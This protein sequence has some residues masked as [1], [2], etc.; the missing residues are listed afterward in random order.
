MS[1][2]TVDALTACIRP[3]VQCIEL[4][5]PKVKREDLGK[6]P[7]K[8]NGPDMGTYDPSKGLKAVEPRV[9]GAE[10]KD[11]PVIKYYEHDIKRS[12]NV[13]GTGHYTVTQA[14]YNRLSKS[15]PSIRIKRH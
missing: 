2:K 5:S 14:M 8:A 4:K 10:W 13:P 1:Y 11:N 15:P 6:K 3:R 12:N 9:I 7:K